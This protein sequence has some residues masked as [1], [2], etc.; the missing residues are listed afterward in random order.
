[1]PPARQWEL[2]GALRVVPDAFNHD[3]RDDWH[4]LPNG[5]RGR[6]AA[7][8]CVGPPPAAALSWRWSGLVQPTRER[9][10][11][12]VAPAA[13]DNRRAPCARTVSVEVGEAIRL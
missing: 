1:M 3:E 4:L 2:V 6:V 13:M 12:E 8:P 11:Q 10:W 9:W 5:R 7:G